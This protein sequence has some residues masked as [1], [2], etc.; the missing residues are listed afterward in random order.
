MDKEQLKKNMIDKEQFK[1]M[2]Y[3]IILQNYVFFTGYH[4]KDNYDYIIDKFILSNKYKN[5]IL[6]ILAEKILHIIES[7]RNITLKPDKIL[8]ENDKI[9][10]FI[11]NDLYLLFVINNL[12]PIRTCYASNRHIFSNNGHLKSLLILPMLNFKILLAYNKVNKEYFAKT[13]LISLKDD[14]ILLISRSYYNR[15]KLEEAYNL[16]KNITNFPIANFNTTFFG[17]Y[18]D[19]SNLYNFKEEESIAIFNFINQ[20]YEQQNKAFYLDPINSIFVNKKANYSYKEIE[21]EIFKLL[22]IINILSKSKFYF[23]EDAEILFK[24]LFNSNELAN[25][26]FN[27]FYKTLNTCI[28]CEKDK[29]NENEFLCNNCVNN[30]VKYID[31]EIGDFINKDGNYNDYE[32]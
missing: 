4:F 27:Y 24:F 5:N 29:V 30:I 14:N 13:N 28:L 16:D 19:I 32:L 6:N 12:I 9:K 23:I 8:Y 10:I 26:A 7:I 21:A 1:K 11:T 25:K 18:I 2:L 31:K 3:E 15:E 17:D 20:Y 22:S